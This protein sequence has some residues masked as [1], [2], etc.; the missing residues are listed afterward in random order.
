MNDA[1]VGGKTAGKR[2]SKTAVQ[3]DREPD[4]EASLQRLEAI[5]GRL[6]AGELPLEETLRLFEEGQ[7][8]VRSCGTL[9]ERAEQ[10]VKELV[11]GTGATRD[12]AI[13]G[14]GG[15]SASREAGATPPQRSPV[16]PGV[17]RAASGDAGAGAEPDREG[18]N[19]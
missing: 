17:G 10:R 15:P 5:V 12:L 7:T 2:G 8:L 18:A 9:L 13:S 11:E 14:A 19:G 3:A 16:G 4:F 1:E 6:E